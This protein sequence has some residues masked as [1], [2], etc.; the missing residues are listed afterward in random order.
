M[1]STY[2]EGTSV[3]AERYIRTLKV[4]IYKRMTANDSQ[5]Y[6]SYLN[7]LIDQCNNTYHHCIRKKLINADYSALTENIKTIRKTFKFKVDNWVIITKYK[8]IFRKGYTINWSRE[9]FV[10]D[11]MLK[12]NLWT[13]T[14]EKL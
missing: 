4:K 2:N 10:I 6:F 8:N 9:I 13:Y 14:I 5:S 12:T 11:S 1:Y 3:I 7:R